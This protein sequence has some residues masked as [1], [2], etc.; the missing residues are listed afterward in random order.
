LEALAIIVNAL[1][2][3]PFVQN[4]CLDHLLEPPCRAAVQVGCDQICRDVRLDVSAQ[5]NKNLYS[6]PVGGSEIFRTP[7]IANPH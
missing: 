7:L 2:I 6:R 3:L 4:T 1:L 5:R